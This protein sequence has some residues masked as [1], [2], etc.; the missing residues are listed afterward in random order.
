MRVFHNAINDNLLQQ[1]EA[2]FREK[3]L[4]EGDLPEG[5][6]MSS[7]SGIADYLNGLAMQKFRPAEDEIGLP[8]LKIKELRQG[9]FDESTELCSPSIKSEYIVHVLI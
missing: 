5:W 1:A 7:L 2:I 3:L 6:K 9:S 8:V 4:I